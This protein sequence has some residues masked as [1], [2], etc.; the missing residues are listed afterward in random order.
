VIE[1]HTPDPLE[2]LRAEFRRHL[3]IERAQQVRAWRCDQDFS[4]RSVAAAADDAWGLPDW[5]EGGNQIHGAVLCEV[6]AEL[7]GE[8]PGEE[9]WN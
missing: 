6:A 7:L 4:W 3:T 5:L 1:L 9:P 2:I 8:D